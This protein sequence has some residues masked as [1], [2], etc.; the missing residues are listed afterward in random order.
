MSEPHLSPALDSLGELGFAMVGLY[1]LCEGGLREGIPP[2]LGELAAQTEALARRPPGAWRRA[3]TTLLARPAPVDAPLATLTRA[4]GLSALEVLCVALA[5]AV[6]REAL[7]GRSLSI[8]QHPVGGSRPT[9]GLLRASFAVAADEGIDA[10]D[11]LLTGVA[12]DSGL[13]TLGATEL[14]I[15]ERWI[16]IPHHLTLALRGLP[17]QREGCQLGVGEGAPPLAATILDQARRHAR[18][19][20]GRPG[21]ALAI[22]CAS[23]MERRATASAVIDALG[24]RPLFIRGDDHRGIAPWLLLADL[25]PVFERDLGPSERFTVPEL[26]HYDGPV[27]VTTGPDGGIAGRVGAPIAWRVAIPPV[28]DRRRLWARALGDAELAQRLASAHRHSCSRIAELGRLARQQAAMDERDTVRETDVVEA[29]WSSDASGLE[30]LAEPLRARISDEG[31]VLPEVVRRDLQLLLDRC[32]GREGLADGL[33][34]ATSTRYRP[35]VRALLVGPSGTGKTLAAGWLASAL[36]MPLYRVDIASVVSKYIGETEKNLAQ[37]LSRAEDAE[38]VLLFDEADSLFGKRTDVKQSND[39][40]A[41]AQ[42]NY[43]LQRIESFDGITILTSNSRSRFDAAFTR[44]L[45]FVIDFPAPAPDE[46]RGLWR[47]HLGEGHLLSGAEINRLAATVDLAGGHIR[48]AVLCAAVIAR[49]QA[50]PIVWADLVR[51]VQIELRKLGRQVPAGLSA[52]STQTSARAR[53]P[54]SPR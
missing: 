52:G 47:A 36:A 10:I 23:M 50:R 17:S 1:G 25:A 21:A 33:G 15:P 2:E 28:A 42:T 8:V 3:L 18:G 24:K 26:P 48:N 44:R 31:V 46:R 4:L 37:L 12:L 45:D 11:Q 30:A 7:I 6:E 49:G 13:L 32:R 40:F 27:L 35:G 22:R 19:L 54:S 20:E 9:L 53:R 29:A 41:N 39:R 34:I 38:V 43:L 51:G 16:V 5:L 14:P